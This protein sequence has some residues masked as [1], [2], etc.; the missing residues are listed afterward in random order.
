MRSV[1]S[2]E[3]RIPKVPKRGLSLLVSLE[4]TIKLLVVCVVT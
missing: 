2:G 3:K 4:H 1:G